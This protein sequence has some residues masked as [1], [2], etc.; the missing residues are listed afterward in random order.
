[1]DEIVKKI[2]IKKENKHANIIH[3]RDDVFYNDVL[4]KVK[5]KKPS[6]NYLNSNSL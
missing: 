4:K 6:F 3:R 1:M 2:Q 5:S